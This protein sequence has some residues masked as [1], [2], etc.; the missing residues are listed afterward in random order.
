MPDWLLLLLLAVLFI[1]TYLRVS[2]YTQP[3]PALP[4]YSRISFKPHNYKL[5]F[6]QFGFEKI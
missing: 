3:F 2:N 1:V 5:I 4:Q 6:A